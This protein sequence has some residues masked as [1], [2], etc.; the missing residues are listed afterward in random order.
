MSTA[1]K[2]SKKPAKS[3]RATAEALQGTS[4]AIVAPGGLS[5]PEGF[6][7]KRNLQTPSLVMKVP[8]EQR[9]LLF[10]GNME[11]ST[12]KNKKGEASATVADV[13]DFQTGE[14]FKFLVPSVVESS[15]IQAV[16]PDDE[17]LPTGTERLGSDKIRREVYSRTP[18]AG[19]L[20]AIRN[21]GKREGKRHVDFEVVELEA[22]KLHKVTE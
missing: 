13:I 1:K 2:A 18:V 15:L 7:A 12:V 17:P 19:M 20:L 5:L 16:N 9:V 22:P 8:G 11:V 14:L 4:V 3:A 21:A 6:K 10:Q